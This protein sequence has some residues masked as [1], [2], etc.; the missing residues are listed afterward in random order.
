MILQSRDF[1]ISGAQIHF[2]GNYRKIFVSRG[3][4]FFEQSSF[5]KQ[6]AIRARAFDFF[7]TDAAGR[8]GLRIEVEQQHALAER[9]EAG[10]EV[11]GGGGF[12]HAT[13][14]VGDGDDFGWHLL[15]K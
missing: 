10:G 2:A 4:Y 12:S 7:Q 15:I 9:G 8:V 3:F 6:N 11:D 14:L 5:A 1:Q 13:F